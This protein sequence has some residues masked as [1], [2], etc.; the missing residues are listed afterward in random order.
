MADFRD[1]T[2]LLEQFMCAP[3]LLEGESYVSISMIA[4]M[5]WKIR[6]GLLDAIESPQSSK[7]LKQ[8]AIKM[9]NKFEEQWGYGTPGKVVTDHLAEG[10]CQCHC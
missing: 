5:I 4:F 7:Y 8:L 6:R 2:S 1:T 9:N 10:P 3:R